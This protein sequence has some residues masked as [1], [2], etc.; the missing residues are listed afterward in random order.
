MRLSNFFYP[1]C[2]ARCQHIK[3]N[4]IQCGSPALKHKKFCY[5]HQ[6]WQQ[7]RI[8]ITAN[9][10][11]R[12]RAALDLPVLE[13]ANSIQVA[14]MQVMRLLLANQLDP[15][16]GALLLYGLQTASANLRRLEFSPMPEQ[17]V[18]DLHRVRDTNLGDDAWF[19]QE[20]EE[21]EEGNAG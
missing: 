16:R 12:S 17:V 4:G 9:Q 7:R 13:D 21:P 8:Q 15:R 10:A 3:V 18:I 20:F 2:I 11:R 6:Q 19:K 14:L 5:F 1:S